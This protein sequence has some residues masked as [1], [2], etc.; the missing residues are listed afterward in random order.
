MEC[1]Q[2]NVVGSTGTANPATVSFPGA[3]KGTD[4]GV[5]LSIYYPPVTNYIIPGPRPFTCSGGEA[6]N[7][8][9][10]EDEDEDD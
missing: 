9:L 5:Q 3:Y 8:E 4:P 10:K 2:I 1:A 6:P 7:V